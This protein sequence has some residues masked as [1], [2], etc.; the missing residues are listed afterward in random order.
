MLGGVGTIHWAKGFC[1][2]LFLGGLLAVIGCADLTGPLPEVHGTLIGG[3]GSMALTWAPSGHEVTFVSGPYRILNAYNALTGVTRRLWEST[4]ATD[5]I[6]DA[7][8]SADGAEWFTTSY[9]PKSPTE[10]KPVIRRH[11]AAGS[12]IITRTG[13]GLRQSPADGRGVLMAPGDSLVTF[14][15][16]PDSLFLLRR[17]S[18]PTFVGGGCRGLIAFSTDQSQVLCGAQFAPSSFRVFRLDGSGSDSPDFPSDVA[19]S[20]VIFRWDA[21][22]LRVVYFGDGGYWLYEQ[23]SRSRRFLTSPMTGQGVIS[24]HSWAWS[25]DGRATAYWALGYCPPNDYCQGALFVLDLSTGKATR[26]AVHVDRDGGARVAFSPDGTTVAYYITG[27]VYLL[28]VP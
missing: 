23:A 28:K 24:P 27:G 5:Q 25:G 6:Q 20:A 9:D 19:V 7:L 4:T 1:S 8:L 13:Y 17:G 16:Q 12:T 3:G 2:W 18:E 26:V 11:T 14:L 22:G 10:L 21:T 15:V